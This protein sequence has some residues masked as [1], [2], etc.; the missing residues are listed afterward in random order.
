MF[1]CAFQ[2]RLL[3]SFSVCDSPA[4]AGRTASVSAAGVRLSVQTCACDSRSRGGTFGRGALGSLGTTAV[5][6]VGVCSSQKHHPR[7]FGPFTHTRGV[8]PVLT[9]YA[10]EARET[11]HPA[12]R[13]AKRTFF[14]RR[15]SSL[16]GFA[17]G[18]H[19][20]PSARPLGSVGDR[21]AGREALSSRVSS[22]VSV[23]ALVRLDP[24]G[25]A[26]GG[27]GTP[28][29]ARGDFLFVGC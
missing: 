8:T 28:L 26:A 7:G 12:L 10:N 22:C 15:Q 27:E 9:Q 2:S 17:Y 11:S 19:S 24:R 29:K 4:E 5:A 3:S 16:T 23:N 1:P 6:S 18:K 14:D 20:L 25:K 13:P 21:A